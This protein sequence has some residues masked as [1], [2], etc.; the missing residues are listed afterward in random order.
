MAGPDADAIDRSGGD[1][2]P[3][4]EHAGLDFERMLFFSDAV[5]AIAITLLVIELQLPD[6]PERPTGEAVASALASVLPQVFAYAL[7]FATIGLYWYA[8]WRRFRYIVRLDVQLLA[9]NLVQ[10]GLIAFIPFPTAMIGEHGDQPLIVIVYAV[11]LALAGVIGPLTWLYAWRAGLTRPGLSDRFV[12][13]V[14]VRGFSVPLVMVGSLVVLPV[15]GTSAVEI[16]WLLIAP[17]QWL[18]NRG[19]RPIETGHW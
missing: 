19:L 7:S 8:H 18:L 10:L 12:R 17:V 2:E 1:P 15:L 14:A 11:S 13:F 16:G 9:L 6:L 5:F 3:E 4:S